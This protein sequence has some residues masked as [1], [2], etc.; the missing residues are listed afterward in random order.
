MPL[1]GERKAEAQRVR[2]ARKAGKPKRPPAFTALID[3]LATGRFLVVD[4]ETGE[5]YS[6]KV[7]P[8]PKDAIADG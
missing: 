5:E 3:G 4:Q 6:V 7:V 1:Q 8:C 2:R